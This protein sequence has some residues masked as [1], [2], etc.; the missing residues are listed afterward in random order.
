[1]DAVLRK[2]DIAAREALDQSSPSER[3]YVLVRVNGSTG[4][5][6]GQLEQSGMEVHS[7]SG[8]IATGVINALKVTNL[9]ALPFV[10]R[11]ELSRALR[12]ER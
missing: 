6:R 12:A 10:R 7:T 4:S 9:A 1:V 3:L 2:F 8:P 5:L 11:V